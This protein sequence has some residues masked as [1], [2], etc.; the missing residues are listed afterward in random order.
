MAK[1]ITW[2][3]KQQHLIEDVKNLQYLQENNRSEF[4]RVVDKIKGEY[5]HHLEVHKAKI[6]TNTRAEKAKAK[7]HQEDKT[8]KPTFGSQMKALVLA[9]SHNENEA[10]GKAELSSKKKYNQKEVSVLKRVFEASFDYNNEQKVR[11]KEAKTKESKLRKANDGLVK[12]ANVYIK[13]E[14]S[15]VKLS[16]NDKKIKE[17]YLKTIADNNAELIVSRMITNQYRGWFSVAATKA[18]ISI[19]SW[20]KKDVALH[21]LE[22]QVVQNMNFK[23][24]V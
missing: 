24:V 1:A 21:T 3:K 18:K 11:I 19:G 20:F 15:G 14:K 4:I 8:A 22:E 12:L 17:E 6:N 2:A 7:S 13:A 5:A 10:L 16:E 23:G 9:Q